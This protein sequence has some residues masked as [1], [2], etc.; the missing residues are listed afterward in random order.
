MRFIKVWYVLKDGL[1]RLRVGSV[2]NGLFVDSNTFAIAQHLKMEK[3]ELV[4]LEQWE[5]LDKDGYV[6]LDTRFRQIVTEDYLGEWDEIHE[7]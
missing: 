5:R 4:P 2:G 6:I 1:L 7:L 3:T